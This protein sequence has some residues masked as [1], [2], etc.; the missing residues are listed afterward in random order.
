MISNYTVT[1]MTCGNC[2]KHITE[3]V[4]EIQGVSNVHVDHTA[5]TMQIESEQR[6]PFDAVSN[7]VSEAGNYAVTEA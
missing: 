1:G 4:S 3:E 6:I 2:A 7:A 5:G